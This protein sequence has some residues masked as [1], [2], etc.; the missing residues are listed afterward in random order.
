VADH[1]K[2]SMEKHQQVGQSPAVRLGYVIGFLAGSLAA[3]RA[4]KHGPKKFFEWSQEVDEESRE[5]LTEFDTELHEDF[6]A[7]RDSQHN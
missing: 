7:R 5:I 6:T 1:I 3:K 4:L 2:K